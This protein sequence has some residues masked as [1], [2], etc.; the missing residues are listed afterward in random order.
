MLEPPYQQET[1]LPLPE[2]A[3]FL[4]RPDS[5][6]LFFVYPGL[7]RA[8][9]GKNPLFLLRA[10]LGARNLV[11]LRDPLVRFFEQGIDDNYPTFAS[12]LD[13]HRGYIDRQPNLSETYTVGNSSGGF[14]A[15]EMGHHLKVKAVYAFCPRGPGRGPRLR[16]LLSE[17]NGVTEYHL[18]YSSHDQWDTDF[19]EALA[20]TPHLTLHPSDPRHND[21]HKI[22]SQMAQRGDLRAVFPPPKQAD[23]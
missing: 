15:L 16:K 3:S 21:T 13:W 6:Q 4:S 22:M 1:D 23:L 19:S 5:A 14:S 2:G 11:F 9:N 17:W 8:M 10:G 18:Y 7:R 12:V 20:R